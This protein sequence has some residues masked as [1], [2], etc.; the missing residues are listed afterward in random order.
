[1]QIFIVYLHQGINRNVE[2]MF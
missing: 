2:L 1:L